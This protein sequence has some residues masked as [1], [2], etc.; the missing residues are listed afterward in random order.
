MNEWK[1]KRKSEMRL[2]EEEEEGWLGLELW[3]EKFLMSFGFF[4][5]L[6]FFFG[7]KYE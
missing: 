5:M 3:L 4:V 1:K 6:C 2:E 7:L